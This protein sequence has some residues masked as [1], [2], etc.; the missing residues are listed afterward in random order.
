MNQTVTAGEEI[1]SCL[2]V[3]PFSSRHLSERKISIQEGRPKPNLVLRIRDR[4]F[5]DDWYETT[6]WLCSSE[7][8]NRLFC[9]SCLLFRPRA[10]QSWTETGY[11]NMHHFL[12]DCKKHEKAKS[13]MEAYKM[14]RTFDTGKRMDV[15]F[16][17]ARREEID[18]HN[19]HVRQNRDMLKTISEAALF[20]AK[21][22]LPF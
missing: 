5:Q 16:S 17:R 10:S 13:H 12:T 6:D 19:E 2:I 22:E 4:V 1:I 14:W 9:W 7:G 11:C 21:Q 3:N 8:K 18:M 20:L 15:V